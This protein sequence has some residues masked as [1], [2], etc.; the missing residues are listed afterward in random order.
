MQRSYLPAWRAFTLAAA[1]LLLAA[2]AVRAADP[3]FVWLEGEQPTA[4]NVKAN[5]AGWGHPEFL[6]GQK[7]L[8]LSIDADKVDAAVPGD[9]VLIDYAFQVATPGNYQL[10]NRVGFEFVRSPLDWRI[11][12]GPWQRVGPDEL[13]TDVMELDFW[14]EV[15]WLKLG[16]QQL[17]AGPHKLQIRLPKIK[18]AQ[19]KTARIIYASDALC[20]VAGEFSPN[21]PYK[22]GEESHSAEDQA[23]RRHVFPLPAPRSAG[24]RTAVALKGLWEVCRFDEQLPGEVA[25]PIRQLPE[26]PHWS[27]IGVPGDK[28]VLR[29]DLELAHRLWYRTRVEVPQS[30]S[31]R[32]FALVFPQNNLNTTVYVNG[33][34][35]GFNKNPFA[36]F[37]IDVSRAVRPGVNEVWVGIKDAWY[38][39][40]AS[41]NDPLK[42]R[43]TFNL[44][45][46][47]FGDGFQDL[48]YPVWNHPESGILVTPE[49]VAAGPVYAADVFCKPSLARKELALEVTLSNPRGNRAEGQV[50]CEAV[51]A[52]SGAVEKQ[53][54]P[55]PFTLAGGESRTLDIAEPWDHP[56][57]WWPDDPNLYLL[58]A[59]V[60]IGGR[61]V[62]VSETIFG[63]REWSWQGRDFKLNGIVWHG[64]ADCFTA[65]DPQQWIDFYRKT[66]QRVMRFW[67]TTWQDLPPEEALAF[68]DR[69]GVVVR[70]S[71]MLDGE[72]IGYMAVENDAALKK[73]RG[74]ELKLS[75]MKNW[76]DQVVAQ[77]KGERNHPSVMVWSIENEWLYINCINLYGGL[78]DQFEA[79]VRKVSDAVQAADPTRPTMTDGGAANKDNS[80]P[81]CGNH[82]VFGDPPK[83]PD[84]AYEANPQGGGRGRWQWDQQRPRFIGEDYFANGI[85]PFDYA[86]FGGE[87]TFQGKAQSHRAAGIIF[88]MLTEGYRWAGYGAWHLWM[89]QNE[90]RDQYGSNAP[91]AVFCREWDWTF[92]SGQPV[93]RTLK[94]FNDT[95]FD[96]PIDFAWSLTVG[97]RK[98][99]GGTKC[100]QI[101]PGGS[102]QVQGRL[103]MPAVDDRAEGQLLL[104][105]SVKGEEVF[106]DVKRLSVLNADPRRNKAAGLATLAAGDLL[107]C[108]PHG[109]LI[110]FLRRGGIPFTELKDLKTLPD[111][112]RV[113][114]IGKD[115]IG[116]VES[117]SSKFQV[118]AA[119]GRSVIVLEQRHPL[120]Y[121]ALPA[122]LALSENEGRTAFIENLEHPIFA[123]L[124]Q[125]DFFT[126]AGDHVVYRNAYGKPT[127]GGKS[128]VQCDNRLADTALAEVPVGKGLL[129]V[130][131]LLVGEKLPTSA[132][133]QRLLANLIGYAAAYRLEHRP[134]AVCSRDLDPRLAHELEAIQLKYATAGDPLAALETSGVK[135]AIIPASPANLKV[136][137]ANL[138]Q[139]RRFTSGGG[140]IV[141]HGLTPQGL[142]DYNK[143][144]G[145]P[146]MIRPFRRERV[147]FP[148]RRNPLT[149]GL[150]LGDVVM[151]SGERIF[152]WTSDEY[153]ANDIFSY[154]VDFDD[155]A[156]FA[157]FPNDFLEN[158]VNGMVSADAWKYIVNVP[159][160][161]QPPLDWVLKF[162]KPQ[163][164]VEMTWIGNTFY[165]P[166]TKVQL[167]FDGDTA[168][169]A[170]FPTL[171]NNDPQTFPIDPPL[172]GKDLTLR[173][174]D[175][176]K[177]PGKNAVTGLDNIFLKA[178]RS[179]EFYQNVRPML[180]VGGL[181]QYVEGQGGIVLCNL[182]FQEHEA[183]PENAVK[184]RTILA[185]ILR[186]LKAPFAEGKT[187]IA[188]AK[189]HYQ[190]L[191]ISKQCNQFRDERGWFGDKQH[192]LKE[193]PSGRQTFC[194]LPFD[195]Y[196]FP[197][198]PVPT[199]VMLGAGGVPGNLKSEVRGI[200]VGRKADA[201]F[202]LHAARIDARRNPQE[203]KQEKK[204]DMLHYV[205]TYADGQTQNVPIYA[206][207]DID[208]YRQS[209]PAAIPGAQLAWVRPYAGGDLS[210]V[211][212]AKQWN[213]PRPDVAIKSIDM[214][215]GPDRRGPAALV[216]VTAAT[217]E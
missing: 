83:Y 17:A 63:F 115:A 106:R 46:K 202:F 155:V 152:G 196:E 159:A 100:Y 120:R 86:Y 103:Q 62:D 65:K 19:G 47:Y 169:A 188:G 59:T 116:A 67:G 33:T 50:V 185:T 134:V 121:Q 20:L 128:L 87:E 162:P 137:A 148:V 199:V 139:V 130:S 82:Y 140:Q 160:P 81:V 44:P 201:L 93:S 212:Y 190:P 99:G 112:G 70:R 171:P 135:T 147:A 68:F 181:L 142:A 125:Q 161:E 123:G 101:P 91:R 38:G 55:R 168:H 127:R 186:N 194:G 40:A 41:P 172:K 61:V 215:Y 146:H 114:L 39:R 209:S 177:I 27:A 124:A 119:P 184:K 24:A 210:A 21:G 13:T 45:K 16:Q 96:D 217:A 173:L 11:D 192:T 180:N 105:L 92:A 183:V 52:K 29:P 25:A 23:A 2:T 170:T 49:F 66:N 143:L 10:W 69:Q 157:Q 149:A 129:L 108:D 30:E 51:S 156:P 31:A 26:H 12:G 176:E 187:I 182:R 133:A 145:F 206:E 200:P 197:T 110:D 167:F 90:A 214:V 71:G 64:W 198:S 3:P 6:S 15:A 111:A 126:W 75:L 213:N 53:F 18:D 54:E 191:D 165:Y 78:M 144:V 163:E 60:R 117:G 72:A 195:V 141:F 37:A 88:R 138:E 77:V 1:I 9:G 118:Y 97:G 7:W 113:L 84:L 73:L 150:T 58:R 14:C 42:L 166:V 211:L 4:I 85:N 179:K 48:D 104:A 36:R 5:L 132:A 189:L 205:I 208:D 203:I 154:I 164:L 95:R 74:S 80:M 76:Q 131:Q 122:D 98:L 56:Q 79:E 153:V 204:Y 57:L 174:A 107:V 151:R 35:C 207:I 102:R 43:K 178:R 109:T 193:L 216:A 34:Y 89:G 175:W 32:S 28:N 158:M 8:S 94:I 22:P 136:L